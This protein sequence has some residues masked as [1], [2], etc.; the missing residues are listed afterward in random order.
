MCACS[1]IHYVTGVSTGL[2][3]PLLI[4]V[5]YLMRGRIRPHRGIKLGPA[6]QYFKAHSLN[7]VPRS[8]KSLRSYRRGGVLYRI[9]P[10][11]LW[12]CP[13]RPFHP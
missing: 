10:S 11:P 1:D 12:L 5:S 8:Y 9:P 2:G 4:H 3:A 13:S 6:T 7:P